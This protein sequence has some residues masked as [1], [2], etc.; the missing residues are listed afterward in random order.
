MTGKKIAI[1]GMHNQFIDE[2]FR[3]KNARGKKYSFDKA[4]IKC[5]LRKFRYNR[6]YKNESAE[7]E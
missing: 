2:A 1:S 3:W 4:D 5:A 6:D 7:K